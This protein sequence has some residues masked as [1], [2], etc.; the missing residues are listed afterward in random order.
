MILNVRGEATIAN[1]IT[2]IVHK[3]GAAAAPPTTTTPLN[4]Y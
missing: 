1:A 2:H 3:A 4:S